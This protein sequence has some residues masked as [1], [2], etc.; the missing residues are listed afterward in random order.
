LAPALILSFNT[1]E[2]YAEFSIQNLYGYG[3][4]AIALI[5]GFIW[6]HNAERKTK[7]NKEC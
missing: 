1:I 4:L 5:I 2:S 7:E 3:I 6:E